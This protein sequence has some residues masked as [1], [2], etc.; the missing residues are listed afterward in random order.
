[1]RAYEGARWH[2][3]FRAQ[4]ASRNQG[5]IYGM[6][7]PPALIRNLSMRAMGGEKLLSRY[8]WLYS[9]RPPERFEHTS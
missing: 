3:A 9:W 2:R 7:G 6:S 8:D 1:L 4:Q 5:R